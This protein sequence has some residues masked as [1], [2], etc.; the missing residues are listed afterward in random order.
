MDDT[1]TN[2]W[3]L[4]TLTGR[5]P[6]VHTLSPRLIGVKLDPQDGRYRVRY[7]TESADMTS[8]CPRLTLRNHLMA[9]DSRHKVSRLTVSP[10]CCPTSD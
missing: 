1:D 2:N 7:D 3:R 9:K 10:R 5:D 4:G 6:Q 8:V